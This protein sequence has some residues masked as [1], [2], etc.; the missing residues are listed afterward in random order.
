MT[1]LSP[2]ELDKLLDTVLD[3]IQARVEDQ[4]WAGWCLIGLV[5]TS[6]S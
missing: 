4:V 3:A 2:E 1:Y 6:E 5:D